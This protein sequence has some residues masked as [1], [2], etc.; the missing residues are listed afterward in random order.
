MKLTQFQLT[1][2]IVSLNAKGLG[3]SSDAVHLLTFLAN[4]VRADN[5]YSCYPSHPYLMEHLCIGTLRKVKKLIKELESKY[6]ITISYGGGN[7]ANTYHINVDKILVLGKDIIDK[8]I[9]PKYEATTKSIVNK[10]KSRVTEIDNNSD[11]E[12]PY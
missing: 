9:K 6:L 2:I 5:N 1:K 4:H 10:P 7:R 3:V 12:A 11:W 8:I